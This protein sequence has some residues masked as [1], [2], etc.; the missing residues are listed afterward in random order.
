MAKTGRVLNAGLSWSLR[1]T[2]ASPPRTPN[3]GTKTRFPTLRGPPWRQAPAERSP[4]K[5]PRAAEPRPGP[6][7]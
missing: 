1:L 5:F 6:E 2:F 3:A 7:P 4:G